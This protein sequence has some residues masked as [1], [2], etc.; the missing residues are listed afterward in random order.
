MAIYS[1]EDIPSVTPGTESARERLLRVRSRLQAHLEKIEIC[2]EALDKN[3]EFEKL[4][5]ILRDTL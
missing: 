3:P 4:Y 1:K 5:T 2:I